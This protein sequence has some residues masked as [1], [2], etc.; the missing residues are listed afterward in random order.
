CNNTDT[1]TFEFY[2]DNVAPEA[3][4]LSA[5]STTVNPTDVTIPEDPIPVIE[6][7]EEGILLVAEVDFNPRDAGS[8]SANNV[9]DTDATDAVYDV[10]H[11]K[12]YAQKK[13]PLTGALEGTPTLIGVG[14]ST[15]TDAD[16]IDN[17][18]TV[19]WQKD[20]TIIFAAG[21]YDVYAVAVDTHGNLETDT[22]EMVT[23][24]IHDLSGPEITLG[25][26]GLPS[27]YG[28]CE[29]DSIANCNFGNAVFPSDIV[30]F[31]GSDTCHK[32]KISGDVL[33]LY[34]EADTADNIKSGSVYVE[35]EGETTSYMTFYSIDDN[36]INTSNDTVPYIIKLYESDYLNESCD[37]D[38]SRAKFEDVEV[39]IGS[40]TY[41]MEMS[42]NNNNEFVWTATVY[43]PAGG[44]CTASFD[45]D[46]VGDDITGDSDPRNLVENIDIPSS[47]Y[48]TNIDISGMGNGSYIIRAHAEDI[49]DREV[50]VSKRIIID[51]TPPEITYEDMQLLVSD[52]VN[53]CDTIAGKQIRTEDRVRSGHEFT[54][55]A[56]I[57][58]PRGLTPDDPENINRIGI[59]KVVFQLSKNGNDTAGKSYWVDIATDSNDSDGWQITVGA[60]S[61]PNITNQ[62]MDWR[63]RAVPVDDAMNA[64]HCA[65]GKEITIDGTEPKAEITAMTVNDSPV[66]MIQKGDV[67]GLEAEVV[68]NDDDDIGR[69]Y[70]VVFQY[71][72]GKSDTAGNEIWYD[73][74]AN[75]AIPSDTECPNNTVFDPDDDGIYH[76]DW[77]T[78]ESQL[79]DSVDAYIQI[80]AVA[81]DLVG[82]KDSKPTP[83]VL[84]LD[85]STAPNA[86]ITWIKNCI[87]RNILDPYLA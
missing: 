50:T 35:I 27:T 75:G 16:K 67:I 21:T 24:V 52:V 76:L 42:Q 61:F 10:C 11:V 29:I 78:A 62:N 58:D 41:S 74:L 3:R 34:V 43:L 55:T 30:E 39:T 79:P 26:V 7:P 49:L 23:V 64:L 68:L 38:Q 8:W 57:T 65:D 85:D 4:L 37:P 69:I 9:G 46:T 73:I 48:Y 22:S 20:D 51:R 17:R 83:Q 47:L 13:N 72:L 31:N 59:D 70:G 84:I 32:T 15:D 25:G 82:N 54:L 36:S 1:K 86:Y 87:N 19:R 6:W 60:S 12:F 80:R 40:K 77:Y 45:I 18:Y 56:V 44:N 71:S 66:V 81:E 63:F 14:D 53:D 33:N 5:D 2:A 28:L